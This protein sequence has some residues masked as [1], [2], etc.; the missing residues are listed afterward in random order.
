[1]SPPQFGIGFLKKMSSALR[2]NS[3][4]QSGS[5]FIQDISRTIASSRPRLGLK[6]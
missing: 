4:I 5:P 6:T 1:M 3:R 2:R